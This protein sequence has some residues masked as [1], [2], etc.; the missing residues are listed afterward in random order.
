MTDIT[1][2]QSYRHDDSQVVGPAYVSA[3]YFDDRY[4]FAKQVEIPEGQTIISVEDIPDEPTD[5]YVIDSEA[6][7]KS[8]PFQFEEEPNFE[9]IL[10]VTKPKFKPISLLKLNRYKIDPRAR[11]RCNSEFTKKLLEKKPIGS[12]ERLEVG[13]RI[14]R[15]AN[16]RKEYH[17]LSYLSNSQRPIHCASS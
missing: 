10:Q 6:H 15:F 12:I 7:E 13:R 1:I 3:I 9:N 17:P 11:N 2:C 14:I 8:G 4:I 5:Y 16:R